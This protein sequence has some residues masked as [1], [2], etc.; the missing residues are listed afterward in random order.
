MGLACS[1]LVIALLS[2]CAT[3]QGGSTAAVESAPQTELSHK[4][5]QY[6]AA[7]PKVKLSE[8]TSVEIK[9]TDIAANY[10]TEGNWKSAGKIDTMIQ[11]GLK[12]RWPN[13]KIIP[14]NGEFSKGNERTLQI[15][16]C[17]DDIH[18]VSVAA[19][20]WIGVMAGGSDLVMHVDFRDSATGELVANPQFWSGNNAWQGGASHGQADNQIRDSVSSQIVGYTLSN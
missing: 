13:L 8:F 16:P 12:S 20:V 2:G 17:I 4:E 10:R 3:N 5:R 9:A 11:G 18:I 7:P 19:R 14:A 15:I 6:I 1:S